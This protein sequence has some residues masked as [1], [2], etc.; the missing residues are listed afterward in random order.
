MVPDE[1]IPAASARGARRAIALTLLCCAAALLGSG[2]RRCVTPRSLDASPATEAPPGRDA[3][4]YLSDVWIR[5]GRAHVI[6]LN[7]L[8]PARRTALRAQLARASTA[9]DDDGGWV[10]PL[11]PLERGSAAARALF[12]TLDVA[13]VELPDLRLLGTRIE[14]ATPRL[15]VQRYWRRVDGVGLSLRED[16]LTP[17]LAVAQLRERD[18]VAVASLPAQL[19]V[20]RTP[21]GRARTVLC[22]TDSRARCT[23]SV[24]DDVDH[25]SQPRWGRVWLVD[26][27]RRLAARAPA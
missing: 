21:Q 5:I 2:C 16:A 24:D 7:D 22:W 1:D 19:R 17:R 8:P 25:P 12:P 18:N 3:E 15:R 26:V 9:A 13:G 20:Q 10:D 6:S 11:P 4:P 23:L 14:A 27:A